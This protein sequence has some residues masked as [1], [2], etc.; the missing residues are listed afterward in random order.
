MDY[1]LTA[2]EIAALAA[3]DLGIGSAEYHAKHH[4]SMPQAECVLHRS[5]CPQCA[6][7]GPQSR[8]HRLHPAL[9]PSRNV[10]R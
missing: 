9:A 2:E 3:E 10:C 5:D 8:D 6:A 1:V 4:G 7:A